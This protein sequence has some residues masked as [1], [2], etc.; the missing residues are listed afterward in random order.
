LI[1]AFLDERLYEKEWNNADP[2]T[3]LLL[4]KDVDWHKLSKSIKG[5]LKTKDPK[6]TNTLFLRPFSEGYLYN[7]YENGILTGGRI[8]YVRLFLL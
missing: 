3:Y 2:Y 4:D 8:E 7:K 6:T 5:F 1:I